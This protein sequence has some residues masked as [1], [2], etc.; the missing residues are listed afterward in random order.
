[1]SYVRSV[2]RICTVRPRLGSRK[3]TR[4]ETDFRKVSVGGG[5]RNVFTGEESLRQGPVT[6]D[7]DVREGSG[8]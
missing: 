1:M 4:R 3:R 6:V 7:Y 5:A 2:C 8:L